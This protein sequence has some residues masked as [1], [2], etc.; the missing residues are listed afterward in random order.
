MAH[1]SPAW[2]STIAIFYLLTSLALSHPI[3][4]AK[5]IQKI[6]AHSRD[7]LS[8][9]TSTLFSIQ[10]AHFQKL[11]FSSD[12]GILKD[13]LTQNFAP[14]KFR[15]NL[16]PQNPHPE[17]TEPPILDPKNQYE[18]CQKITH[19]KFNTLLLLCQN[20]LT[21]LVL[22]PDNTT[23]L[24]IKKY[25]LQKSITPLSTS[26]NDSESI[27]YSK[28]SRFKTKNEYFVGKN[29]FFGDKKIF[30]GKIIRIHYMGDNV[31]VQCGEIGVS[32]KV[33]YRVILVR[34]D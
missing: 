26:K 12:I 1:P 22:S 24:E 23:I 3:I 27:F 30:C 15:P 19:Y 18:N 9:D 33:V 14:I 34:V 4:E 31:L 10:H 8:I 6:S 16:K 17:T 21:Y 2:L 11:T 13:Q 5:P 29:G 25:D 28:L 20:I 7:I 32:N